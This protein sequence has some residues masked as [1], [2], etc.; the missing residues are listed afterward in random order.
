MSRMC[1][2]ILPDDKIENEALKVEVLRLKEQLKAL[3]FKREGC[4]K[5][6]VS[7]V[8]KRT[9]RNMAE[10]TISSQSKQPTDHRRSQSKGRKY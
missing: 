2:L 6:Q 7:T 4:C 3:V 1:R 10:T 8:H 9:R 5:G